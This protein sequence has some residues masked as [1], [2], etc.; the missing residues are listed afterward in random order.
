MHFKV[1]SVAQ[2][3]YLKDDFLSIKRSCLNIKIKKMYKMEIN[4]FKIVYLVQNWLHFWNCLSSLYIN[5]LIF[6]K[7]IK[8]LRL[9]SY[10]WIN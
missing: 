6:G 2:D 4:I 8:Y 7:H 1:F 10:D 3:K 9:Y 5:F